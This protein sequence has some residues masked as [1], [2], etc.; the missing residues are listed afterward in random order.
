MDPVSH[1]VIGS[2]VAALVPPGTH[3]AV[4]WGIL[5]GSEIPDID[6][7]VRYW[8]GQV[9][10][11]KNHR[12]PTHG[13]AVL[14]LHAGIIAG[15]LRLIWPEAAFWAIYQWSL[16]GCL[17]H[18]LFDFGNDYGTQGLWPFVRKW[19]A[20][21]IIPIVDVYLLGLIALGWLVNW[22]FPGHR[23]A[24]FADVWLAT[25]A[26]IGLR[27]ALRRKGYRLVV[28]RFDLS[29][30]CSEAAPCG[31][32][33]RPERLTVHPTML[34]LNAWR[35]VVQAP[36]EYLVGMVWL[37]E[38]RVGA[39]DRAR[40]EWDRVVKASLQAQIV[41]A[42]AGWVRVPRVQVDRQEDMYRVTWTDMR[43]EMEDFSPFTA[44]AWLDESLTLVDEGLGTQRPQAIDRG[45][46]KRQLRKHTGRQEP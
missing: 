6:F 42:F 31:S 36:G 12:G 34:S 40:N 32:G 39:P 10:Y 22:L 45:T 30:E 18:V 1:A 17:S 16:L 11:L 8:G 2:A 43:Y 37:R 41:S 14:L 33:W 15:V 20:L 24:V 19:I 7:V 29:G 46:L 28:N 21:D 25:A 5:I 44:Y 23:Q 4:V 38:G 35:Y 27:L 13:L 3:Q 9:T 26:Y